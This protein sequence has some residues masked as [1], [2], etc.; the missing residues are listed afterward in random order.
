[1]EPVI[2]IP[3]NW[4]FEV[5]MKSRRSGVVFSVNFLDNFDFVIPFRVTK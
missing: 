1:M 3:I 5:R 2:D 4:N